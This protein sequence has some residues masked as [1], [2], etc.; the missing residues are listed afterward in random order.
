MTPCGAAMD[1]GGSRKEGMPVGIE[2]WTVF[3]TWVSKR[4]PSCWR[5]DVGVGEG[6]GWGV[7][8]S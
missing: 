8:S 2:S 3:R 5:E 7:L 1:G 4:M 6:G